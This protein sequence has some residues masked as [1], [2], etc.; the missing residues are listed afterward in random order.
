MNLQ[1]PKIKSYIG[2][3]IR[4]REITYGVDDIVKT[5]KSKIIL[6]SKDLGE[7]SLSKLNKFADSKN[8]EEILFDSATYAE[9]MQNENIKAA[10]VENKNLA[11]AIKKNIG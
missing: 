7:S 8:I 6:A 1:I 3:A 5:K 10:S 4:S 11:E 9:I 2:F